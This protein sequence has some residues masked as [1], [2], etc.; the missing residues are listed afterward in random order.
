MGIIDD[1]F[2]LESDE[3]G[4]REEDINT[5]RQVYDEECL[6]SHGETGYD[7]LHFLQLPVSQIHF[8]F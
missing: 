2:K 7:G 6:C 4:D 1:A 5:G 3:D 8:I